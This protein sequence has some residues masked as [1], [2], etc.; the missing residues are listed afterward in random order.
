M[1]KHIAVGAALALGFGTQVF[2]AD[3]GFSYNLGE[4]GYT[5]SEIDDLDL[6]G[7]GVTLGG[8]V[9]FAPNIFGSFNFAD[10]DYGSSAATAGVKIKGTTYSLGVG[11]H[12]ALGPKLDLVSGVTYEHVKV[13][14]SSG[15]ISASDS[16]SGFGLNAGLRGRAGDQLELTGTIKYVNFGHGADDF[17]FGAGGR[18]YFTEAFAAGPDVSH[19]DDGTHWGISFRYDFGKR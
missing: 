6:K 9:E 12:W 4:I 7:D 5:R 13:K 1:R 2:A 8:S 10:V 15:G 3:E 19:N 14:G 11:S 16:E 18:W 17:T